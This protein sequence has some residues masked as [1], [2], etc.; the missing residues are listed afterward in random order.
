MATSFIFGGKKV[1]KPGVYGTVESGVNN[2]RLELDSGTVLIIDKDPLSVHGNGAGIAGAAT[3]GKDSFYTFTSITQFQKWIGGGQW[4][5]MAVPLFKP[6]G[7][8]IN[9]AS[10]IVYTRALTTVAATMTLA[11][12]S[13]PTLKFGLLNEG[14]SGNGVEVSSVLTQGYAITLTAGVNDAAKFILKFWRGS[15]VGLDSNGNSYNNIAAADTSPI[16]IAQSSEE[17]TVEDMLLWAVNDIDF[18]NNFTIVTGA[19]FTGAIVAGDITTL[20]GNNLYSGGTSAYDTARVTEALTAIKDVDI[21]FILTEDQAANATSVD[22]LKIAAYL[23]TQMN[24][25]AMYIIG[26]AATSGNFAAQSVAAAA[27]HNS[28]NVVVVHGGCYVSNPGDLV[29]PLRLKDSLYKAALA[30]G[31]LAGLDAQTPPTFKGLSIAGEAHSLTDEEVS[32]GLDAGVLMT[33]YSSELEF[34]SI[35]QGINSVQ[36]NTFVVNSDGSTHQISLVRIMR[37]LLAGMKKQ[38]VL[39]LLGN[40]VS[41]P[42]RNTIDS[43][44]VRVWVVNYLKDVESTNTV[45]NLIISSSDVTVEV[46]SDAY[47][48]QFGINPNYEVNKIFLTARILDDTSG[49]S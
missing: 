13:N 47:K 8:K 11:I 38:A 16:L 29:N 35:V 3:S 46:E 12:A 15:F 2:P 37:Q 6:F 30:T 9:G 22:A 19:A 20:L 25:P 17:D 39:D 31:R 44:T 4:Y 48:I 24:D 7:S 21:N 42:N 1:D 43:E 28:Q 49:L 33:R 18:V 10:N 26:G 36:L 45:D 40:Q 14:I 27:A 34:F 23:D 41:G 5:D 32:I